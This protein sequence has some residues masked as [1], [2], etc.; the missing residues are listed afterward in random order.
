LV[1]GRVVFFFTPWFAFMVTL[2][3]LGNVFKVEYTSMPWLARA[4]INLL[5]I[6]GCLMLTVYLQPYFKQYI[7]V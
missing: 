2:V 4:A 5:L 6:G 3:L 7:L 1:G